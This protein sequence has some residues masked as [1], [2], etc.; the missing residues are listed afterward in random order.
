MWNG[1]G[2]RDE[3]WHSVDRVTDMP[4]L[5]AIGT[6]PSQPE[7]RVYDFS[8]EA[9]PAGLKVVRTEYGETFFCKACDRQAVTNYL[10]PG[11]LYSR[12]K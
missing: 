4:E 7:G 10:G 8:V 12:S 1:T 11:P 5:R 3:G 2:T 9:I 6:C